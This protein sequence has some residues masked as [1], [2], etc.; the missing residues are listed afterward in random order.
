MKTKIKKSELEKIHNIACSD[1]KKRIVDYAKRNPFGDEIEFTEKEI[2]EMLSASTADQLPTVKE[3]FEVVES[4]GNTKT[5]DDAIKQLG[6]KDGEVKALRVLQS[7]K[8]PRHILAE[9]ELVVI[10]KAINDGWIANY[11]DHNQYKYYPWWYLG[12]NFRL[13]YVGCD[14]SNSDCSAR[15]VLESREKAEYVSSQFKELYKEYLNN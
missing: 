8:L 3:V 7:V 4:Y 15:L 12:K 14:Y 6:E 1:W 11:D 10:I 13:N 5:L 9:Q 2:K